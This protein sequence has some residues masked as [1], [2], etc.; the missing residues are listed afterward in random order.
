MLAMTMTMRMRPAGL[1]DGLIEELETTPSS[2]RRA[3]LI[4]KLALSHMTEVIGTLVP[5]LADE[6]RVR[7]AAVEALVSFG[8]DAR[9][10]MLDVLSD[11]RRPDLHPGAVLVLAG[12]VRKAAGASP[13]REGRP[14]VGG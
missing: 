13:S 1:L 2:S 12:I 11:A 5:F 4:R 3:H 6:G 9:R 10:P 8:E 7:R 14:S